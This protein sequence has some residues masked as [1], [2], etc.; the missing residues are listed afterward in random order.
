MATVKR[1]TAQGGTSSC[2]LDSD[3]DYEAS[4]ENLQYNCMIQCFKYFFFNTIFLLNLPCVM[5]IN[6]HARATLSDVC[7]IV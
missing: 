7:V 4:R 5:H 3:F 2:L 1:G 6:L